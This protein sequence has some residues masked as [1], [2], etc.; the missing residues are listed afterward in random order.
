M[1]WKL[2]NVLRRM[3]R[4]SVWKTL[5][6]NFAMLPF[7]Q[8]R[9]L[10]IIISKN[11]HFFDLSGEVEIDGPVSRGM[12]RFSFFG[13]DTDM[14]KSA[15]TILKIKGKL[16]FRGSSHYGSG[17]V[18]RVER[19]ALLEIGD[20]VRVSNRTKI[21]CYKHVSIGSNNRIAW[22]CQIIDTTFHFIRQ[23]EDKRVLPRDG[24]I[25]IGNNN[26]IGNR[27]SI[28][29]GA[30]TPN[31]CIVAGASL[32]NKKYDIPEYSLLAGSPAKLMKT[33]IYRVLD[34]EEDIIIKDL[35]L[36]A[37]R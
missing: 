9:K 12:I 10:P 13:E 25:R 20:N 32:C 37:G 36:E 18:F 21:I 24:A 2:I 6:F 34:D 11:V 29:K 3:L 8:A 7:G 1:N 28:M 26:W 14:W 27:C 31:F 30:V 33:G 17:V 15:R 5:Y 4:V 22:E 35:N 19:G 23:I 16:V